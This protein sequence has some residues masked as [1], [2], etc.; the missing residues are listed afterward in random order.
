VCTPHKA[1]ILTQR[2]QL[3]AQIY[4]LVI[5][6]Q[7]ASCSS[8]KYGQARAKQYKATAFDLWTPLSL[9]GISVARMVE[10]VKDYEPIC[11]Q[12]HRHLFARA[13]EVCGRSRC[14]HDGTADFADKVEALK[15]TFCVV[16]RVDPVRS[17]GGGRHRV[18][19]H[20]L[21]IAFGESTLVQTESGSTSQPLWKLCPS[22]HACYERK[23]SEPASDRTRRDAQNL[24]CRAA[25][26][27][28]KS[29]AS[30]RNLEFVQPIKTMRGK[31]KVSGQI[32]LHQTQPRLPMFCRHVQ[33]PR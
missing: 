8:C 2:S 16:I 22:H 14:R 1:P 23:L 9:L 6:F 31:P 17:S 25:L 32:M 15:Y 3:K 33:P 28:P 26:Q 30:K 19:E 24:P 18:R 5:D 27:S 11:A 21:G 20:W 4:Q 10:D 13:K 12:I 7:K 29:E